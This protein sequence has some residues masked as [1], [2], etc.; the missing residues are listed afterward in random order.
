MAL[1]SVVE[2]SQERYVRI[3]FRPKAESRKHISIEEI[4]EN[5]DTSMNADGE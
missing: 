4:H 2:A 3:G 5:C 1:T